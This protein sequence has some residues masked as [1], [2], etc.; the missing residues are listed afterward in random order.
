MITLPWTAACRAG[1]QRGVP[2]SVPPEIPLGTV[3][4]TGTEPGSTYAGHFFG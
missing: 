1:S 3:Q 4:I 2:L